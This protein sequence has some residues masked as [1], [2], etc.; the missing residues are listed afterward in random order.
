MQFEFVT[1]GTILF[2]AGKLRGASHTVKSAGKR[3]LGPRARQF[4][5]PS[6]LAPWQLEQCCA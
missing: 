2:G 3:P 4:G 1:G 5:W 6:S